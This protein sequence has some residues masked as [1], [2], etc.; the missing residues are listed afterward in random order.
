MSKSVLSIQPEFYSLKVLKNEFTDR[1]IHDV[2]SSRTNSFDY[3]KAFLFKDYAP[4]IFLRIRR[5]YGITDYGRSVGPENL[6]GNLLFGKLNSLTELG[7]SGKSGSFFYYTSD[8]NYMIKTISTDEA[9]L[10]RKLLPRY[11]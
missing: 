1:Y 6:V 5:K 8:C 11:F 2:V 10:L 4:T 3:R 7:S 9:I